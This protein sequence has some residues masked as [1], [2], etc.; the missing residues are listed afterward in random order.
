M[1]DGKGRQG[2]F[3][4]QGMPLQSACALLH[5]RAKLLAKS[6]ATPA[7]IP[8]PP[9]TSSVPVPL[10]TAE[11]SLCVRLLR[12]VWFNLSKFCGLASIST[13]VHPKHFSSRY[14]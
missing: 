5:W 13:P 6:L 8:P 7:T 14:D 2:T 11:C 4:T 9:I 3:D 1:I 10:H 12:C